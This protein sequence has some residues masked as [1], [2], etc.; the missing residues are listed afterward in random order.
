MAQGVNDQG[1]FIPKDYNIKTSV[2]IYISGN[3]Q[4]LPPIGQWDTSQITNMSEL[5]KNKRLFNED[6]SNWN[7]SNVI[8][9]TSMFDGARNFNQDIGN[10]NVSNVRYM[11]SMFFGAHNFNQDISGWNVSNVTSMAGMF[12]GSWFNGPLNNWDVSNVRNMQAMFMRSLYNQPLNNWNV[13]N[14]R[15]MGYMFKEAINFN[16]DLSMWQVNPL[17][18]TRFMFDGALSMTETFKPLRVQEQ[19]PDISNRVNQSQQREIQQQRQQQAISRAQQA[20]QNIGN[21][22]NYEDCVICR[23]PLDNTDGPG[24][25]NKCR[26]NCNDV[27]KVCKNNHMFHRG[28]ILQACNAESVDVASQM[29]FSQFSTLHPQAR[30]SK[31]PLCTNPLNPTCEELVTSPKVPNNDLLLKSTGG[32]KRKTNKRKTNKKRTNKRITKK[33]RRLSNLKSN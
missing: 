13:S 16:Q 10:W 22:S 21:V 27:V 28:C 20:A 33:K 2:N 7:V 32:R 18:D 1:I 15:N 4:K 3:P 12:A 9:M 6:I 5:F 23:E 8:F 29:G 11:D 31:C 25:S 19:T 30:T 26:E 17:A 14:V 24:P